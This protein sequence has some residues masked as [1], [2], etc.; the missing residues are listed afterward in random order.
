MK[1]DKL[2]YDLIF[3]A[4]TAFI[5]HITDYIEDIYKYDR[6]IKKIKAILSKSGVKIQRESVEVTMSAVNWSL[7]LKR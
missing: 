3:S 6:F 4:Y 7:K 1:E 5:I 2:I